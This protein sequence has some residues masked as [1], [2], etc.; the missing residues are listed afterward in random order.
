MKAAH[1][2]ALGHAI[3]QERFVL[4][5][6]ILRGIEIFNTC[7]AIDRHD[8]VA[9]TMQVC[10]HLGAIRRDFR[11]QNWPV[12][13]PTSKPT[14]SI[15]EKGVV[16]LEHALRKASTSGMFLA[17]QARRNNRLFAPIQI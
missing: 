8:P 1:V 15:T 16:R 7:V 2:I 17:L 5:W 6:K 12:A 13:R 14:R 9:K 10:K 3:N 4:N 11:Y